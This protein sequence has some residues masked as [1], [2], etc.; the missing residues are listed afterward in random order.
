[1]SAEINILDYYDDAG[2]ELP[3]LTGTRFSPTA[4]RRSVNALLRRVFY[5]C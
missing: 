5:W 3:Q 2:T 1:M 4:L